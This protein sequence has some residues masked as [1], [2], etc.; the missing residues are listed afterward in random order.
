[1]I[2]KAFII[3]F[4]VA[5]I[6]LV[7]GVAVVNSVTENIDCPDPNTYADGAEACESAKS[8]A[9]T[10]IGILPVAL[11]FAIY[12]IFGGTDSDPFNG[13]KIRNDINEANP[14]FITKILLVLG[15][16]HKKEIKKDDG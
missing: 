10:V 12:M 4:V 1:M 16:A 5:S 15:L 13:R 8:S 6:G 7:F 3:A 9:F 14:N 2:S 11:F